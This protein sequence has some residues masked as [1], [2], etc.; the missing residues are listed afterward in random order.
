[1]CHVQQFVWKQNELD[2][3][4]SSRDI[5]YRHDLCYFIVFLLIK[6]MRVI[7]YGDYV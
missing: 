2:F 4:L 6:Q 3:L 5:D 1:M 7:N